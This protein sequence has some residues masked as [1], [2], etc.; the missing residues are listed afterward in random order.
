VSGAADQQCRREPEDYE[1]RTPVN[2]RSSAKL[3]E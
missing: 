3:Y 1:R 2:R